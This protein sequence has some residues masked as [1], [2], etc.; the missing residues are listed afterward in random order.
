ML[1][2][3]DKRLKLSIIIYR[4][5]LMRDY[6]RER[7]FTS[8]IFNHITI[9]SYDLLY[10]TSSMSAI[11]FRLARVVREYVIFPVRRCTRDWKVIATYR[12]KISESRMGTKISP[13]DVAKTL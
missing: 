7:D 5:T 11:F 12:K 4:Y 6:K 2:T 13:Q 10:R 8:F 1:G 9:P 3:R